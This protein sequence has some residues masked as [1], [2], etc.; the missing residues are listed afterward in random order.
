MQF[1][2]CVIY[3][4]SFYLDAMPNSVVFD[5]KLGTDSSLIRTLRFN[6]DQGHLGFIILFIPANNTIFVLTTS[7]NF[8]CPTKK[9]IYNKYLR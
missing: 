7:G 3:F 6:D 2:G 5:V 8:G 4:V 1:K 9:C